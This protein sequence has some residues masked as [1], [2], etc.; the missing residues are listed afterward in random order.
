MKLSKLI[1]AFDRH[2]ST[3]AMVVALVL[4]MVLYRCEWLN[5][6]KAVEPLCGRDF[7][8]YFI[9]IYVSTALGALVLGFLFYQYWFRCA[10]CFIGP[11]LIIR[12]V[13]FLADAG[14][15]NLWPLFLATDVVHF[16]VI[17]LLF[18]I[19]ARIRRRF[20]WKSVSEPEKN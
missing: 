5:L 13:A 1:F 2:R 15:S 19:S 6:L 7:N 12:H 18:Y 3:S 17:I 8:A 20:G 16:S 4:G 10:M 9:V 11:P 14:P